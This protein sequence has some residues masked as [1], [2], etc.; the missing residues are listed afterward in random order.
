MADTITREQAEAALAA[1]R[2]Q[3]KSYLLDEAVAGPYLIEGW[4]A[5]SSRSVAWV[6][7]WDDYAPFE[8]AYSAQDGGLDEELSSLMETAVHTPPAASWPQGVRSEPYTSYVLAL[9]PDN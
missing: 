5:P 9:Y 4:E 7:G 3:F 1:V 8:W 6:I 2:E